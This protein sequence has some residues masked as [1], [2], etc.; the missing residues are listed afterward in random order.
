MKLFLIFH[1]IMYDFINYFCEVDK[2]Q[3]DVWN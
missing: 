3:N 2:R 1:V